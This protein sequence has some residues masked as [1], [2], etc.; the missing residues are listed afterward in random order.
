MTE[1]GK[2]SGEAEQDATAENSREAAPQ[3]QG[4]QHHPRA[5]LVRFD[6][7]GQ[8]WCDHLECWCCYR[9]MKIGEALGYRC[10]AERSGKLLI[11]EGMEAWAAYVR[12]ERAFL[13]AWAT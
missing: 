5:R 10:L 9:L 7:A 1:E 11:A 6:P 8:A 4:C 13:I 12:R 2:F 3:G